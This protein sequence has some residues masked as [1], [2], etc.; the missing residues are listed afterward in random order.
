MIIIFLCGKMLGLLDIDCKSQATAL[1]QLLKIDMIH[2][3]FKVALMAILAINF[4]FL[5]LTQQLTHDQSQNVWGVAS[6]GICGG[7]CILTN[8]FHE[9]DIYCNIEVG[10]LSANSLWVWL[11]PLDQRYEI[12]LRG[13]DGRRIRQLKPLFLAKRIPG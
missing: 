5:A 8:S 1:K 4:P 12:E 6:N 10:S 3:A 9:N 11:P 13:P 2:S 7:F